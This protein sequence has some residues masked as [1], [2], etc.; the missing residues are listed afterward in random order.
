MPLSHSLEDTH[1]FPYFYLDFNNLPEF[2]NS[3]K[4]STLLKQLFL[5]ILIAMMKFFLSS[6]Y[7]ENLE[8][9]NLVNLSRIFSSWR[10]LYFHPQVFCEDWFLGEDWTKM[11]AT[12]VEADRFLMRFGN[13]VFVPLDRNWRS[14]SSTWKRYEK[15]L[16]V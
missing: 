5:K 13:S 14:S 11:S 4:R 1:F 3:H 2:S 12:D 10:L 9:P 7:R 8:K 16:I 15:H 6:I